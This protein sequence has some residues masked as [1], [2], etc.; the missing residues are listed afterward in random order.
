MDGWARYNPDDPE[1][2]DEEFDSP[3]EIDAIFRSQRRLGLLYGSAFLLVTMTIPVLTLTSRY[4]TS[5]PVLG[6]FSLNFLVVAAL[7]HVVY[8][9]IGAGYA[10]QAN[11]LEQ[12]LLGRR[13]KQGDW[14]C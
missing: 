5:T 6:G 7:Y 8:G 9:L 13:R 14:E 4:W 1:W 11:R 2:L 12:E 3:A 10:L